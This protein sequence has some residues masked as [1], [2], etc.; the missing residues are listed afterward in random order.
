MAY[1]M[2][3]TASIFYNIDYCSRLT[4]KASTLS[5]MPLGSQTKIGCFFQISRNFIFCLFSTFAE[6][7]QL[8]LHL[9]RRKIF[10]LSLQI[11]RFL[12]SWGLNDL[13]KPQGY[14]S[15]DE[16]ERVSACHLCDVCCNFVSFVNLNIWVIRQN[17]KE[18]I[19]RNFFSSF[20]FEEKKERKAGPRNLR[21]KWGS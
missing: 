15:E 8:Q 19:F 11:V 6:L 9:R 4:L 2:Q 3:R 12:R 5:F 21:K 16:W 13:V 18:Q 7:H 14:Q 10:P 1:S 17:S 20:Y